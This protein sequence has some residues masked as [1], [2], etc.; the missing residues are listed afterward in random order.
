[1]LG[2][3]IQPPP[4]KEKLLRRAFFSKPYLQ[5]DVGPDR[6]REDSREGS[7]ARGSAVK[8]LHGDKGAGGG[9]F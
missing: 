7:L 8:A 3:G 2:K 1:M 9:H 5:D 6:H 4:P